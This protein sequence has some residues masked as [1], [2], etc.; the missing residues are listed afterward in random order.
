MKTK[1]KLIFDNSSSALKKNLTFRSEFDRRRK[2][3]ESRNLAETN[4]REFTNYPRKKSSF[5]HLFDFIFDS[6]YPFLS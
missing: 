6:V 5:S 3:T 2:N 1:N 4:Q